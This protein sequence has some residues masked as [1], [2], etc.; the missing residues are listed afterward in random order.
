MTQLE[1]APTVRIETRIRFHRLGFGRPMIRASP[2]STKIC[3]ICVIC[4]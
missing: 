3:V 4:G 1:A 2:T